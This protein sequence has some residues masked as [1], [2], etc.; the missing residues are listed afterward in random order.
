[1]VVAAQ[2]AFTYVPF[3]QGGV[4]DGAGRALDGALI[5]GIGVALLIVVEI[6][7]RLPRAIGAGGLSPGNALAVVWL[8]HSTGEGRF[9]IS[10]GL[11]VGLAFRFAGEAAPHQIA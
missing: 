7:K 10:Q 5:V 4:R 9:S 2:L 6:E 11:L 3:M 8:P 1:M